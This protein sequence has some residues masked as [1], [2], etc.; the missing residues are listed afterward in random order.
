MSTLL[1]IESGR[2]ATVATF[3]KASALLGAGRYSEVYK[4]F[5]TNSQTDVALKLYTGFDA[6]VHNRA[7]NETALLTKLGALNSPY[8]PALRRSVKHRINNQNH[9]LLVLELG[10]SVV[11]G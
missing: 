8:F 2:V 4:A 7:K 10:T 5:D 3:Y 1:S 11:S 9:P 6:G